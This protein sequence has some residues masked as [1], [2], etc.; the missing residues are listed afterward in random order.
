MKA[1]LKLPVTGVLF[2]FASVFVGCAAAQNNQGSGRVMLAGEVIDSACA[3][4]AKS[5]DQIIELDALPMGRLIRQGE[6]EPHAFSL[7]LIKCAL[8]RPDPYRPGTNLPDWQHLRVTFE[9]LADG[10][11]RL[12]ATAGTSSGLA[13]RI[14]DLQGQQSTPGV[15]MS[16]ISLT[17]QDQELRYTLQLVGNGRPMAAGS[18]RA[19]VRFRLEYF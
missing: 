15:P 18:H 17:G 14:A 6:G 1:F 4:D 9:G 10:D 7:R 8:T 11:G 5:A 12:F 19:A 2:V 16:L 13:L 3:L